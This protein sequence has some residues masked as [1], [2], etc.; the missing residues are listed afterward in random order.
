VEGKL[1]T[2]VGIE[3][4]DKVEAVVNGKV[5]FLP[6]RLLN[7]ETIKAV[8]VA[9]VPKGLTLR[10]TILILIETETRQTDTPL[11]AT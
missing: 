8:V 4:N 5:C 11:A 9:W 7:V 2:A 3:V 6:L 1:S 10:L